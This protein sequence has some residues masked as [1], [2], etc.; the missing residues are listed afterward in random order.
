[1]C[2]FIYLFGGA[3]LLLLS[4]FFSSCSE[5]GLLLFAVH[6]LLFEVASLIAEHDLGCE[7]LHTCRSGL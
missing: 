6:G 1:M 7:D 5:E 3:R 4:E 2:I